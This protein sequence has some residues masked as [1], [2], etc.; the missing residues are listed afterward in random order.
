MIVDVALDLQDARSRSAGAA[1]AGPVS[2]S[3]V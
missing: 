2:P 1:T 3:E